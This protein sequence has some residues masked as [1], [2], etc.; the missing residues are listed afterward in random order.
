MAI[1]KHGYTSDTCMNCGLPTDG[2]TR[3]K[4]CMAM[5]ARAN[6]ARRGRYRAEGRCTICGTP[7]PTPNCDRCRTRERNSK[8]AVRNECIEAYGGRCGCCG[9][10]HAEFLLLSRVVVPGAV[11]QQ[12]VGDHEV[13]KRMYARLKKEGYPPGF[14]VLCANC[15]LAVGLYGQCPHQAAATNPVNTSD[16]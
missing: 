1:N 9:E 7:S 10:E 16:V 4:A 14:Q 15:N 13:P 2:Q 5:T 12:S 3:C 8:Q 11:E 6:K